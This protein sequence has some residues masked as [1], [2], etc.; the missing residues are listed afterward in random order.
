M[1]EL[2]AHFLHPKTLEDNRSRCVQY[3]RSQNPGKK[4]DAIWGALNIIQSSDIVD[5]TSIEQPKQI[6]NLSN[7]SYHDA[8]LNLMATNEL[9]KNWEYD[10]EDISYYRER[11]GGILQEFAQTFPDLYSDF[12]QIINALVFAN[13]PDF[14]GGSV[15]SRIGLIWLSPKRS[16]SNHQWLDHL[17][18]EFAHNC[19]FLDDM[20]NTVFPFS[21]AIMEQEEALVLSSIRQ[22]KRGYDKSFHAA[23]VSLTLI[24][25]Y[26]T[27]GQLDKAKSFIPALMLCIQDLVAKPEYLSDYGQSLLDQLVAHSLDKHRNHYKTMVQV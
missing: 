24:D 10:H 6:W 12:V 27:I 9:P 5:S 14:E 13:K 1:A 7:R 21:A 22:Q 16:W 23:Y 15:S 4:I 19:L 25:F 3:A 2:S 17:I 26:E 18:H 11:I 8:L 20:V